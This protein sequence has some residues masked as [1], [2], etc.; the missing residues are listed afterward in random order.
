LKGH[1][2]FLFMN[3]YAEPRGE[4]F[5]YH[6]L[7]VRFVATVLVAGRTLLRVPSPFASLKESPSRPHRCGPA[8]PARSNAR[9]ALLAAAMNF[10][11]AAP[12]DLLRFLN[13]P[14]IVF[15]IRAIRGRVCK[16]RHERRP[17]RPPLRSIR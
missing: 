9:A 15:T 14:A 16:E 7:I 12:L 1:L 11:P 17:V 2:R 8:M 3:R 6:I 10:T 13:V 4:V 5:D